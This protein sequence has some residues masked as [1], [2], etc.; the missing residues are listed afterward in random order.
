MHVS[1]F[2]QTGGLDALHLLDSYS[3]ASHWPQYV[4]SFVFAV[5]VHPTVAKRPAWH[6]R[7]GLHVVSH[8]PSN[9]LNILLGQFWQTPG[10]VAL[11]CGRNCPAGHTLQLKHFTCAS[12]LQSSLINFPTP[13]L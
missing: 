2:A 6:S 13:Q 7:H 8:P 9:A 4:H 1:H 11:Q 5:S 12:V 3:I 10:C